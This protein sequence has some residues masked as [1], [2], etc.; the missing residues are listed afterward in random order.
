MAKRHDP[1][2]GNRLGPRVAQVVTKAMAQHTAATAGH[3]AKVGT[4]AALDFCKVISH[5]TRGTIGEHAAQVAQMEEAPLWFRKVMSFIAFGEGEWQAMLS[6]AYYGTGVQS[7][8]GALLGNEIAPLVQRTLRQD[9]NSLLPPG[10]AADLVARGLLTFEQGLHEASGQAIAEPRFEAMVAG[11]E[12]QPDMVTVL[13]LLRRGRIGEGAAREILRRGG[14]SQDRANLLLELRYTPPGVADAALQVIK[15]IISQDQ[16]RAVA[17]EN[18]VRESDFDDLVAMTGEPPGVQDLLFA[19]RRGIIGRERLEHGIRQGRLRNEWIDVIESLR[20]VPANTADA[21]RAVVQN[22]LS[23]EE[24]KRIAEENGLDPHHWRWLVETA[25]N[26][27]GPMEMLHLWK[28]GIMSEQEVRQGLRES[29]LKNKY[30]DAILA[31]AKTQ[32]AAR[33]ITSMIQHGVI[34]EKDGITLLLRQGYSPVD[35]ARLVQLG[36][37]QKKGAEERLAKNDVLK[38]YREHTIDE[39]TAVKQ[40][41][42]L[43]YSDHEAKVLLGFEDTRRAI[44]FRDQ[45]ISRVHTLYVN[46]HLDEAGASADL[47]VLGV[48]SAERD[49]LMALW[50]L[51][52]SGNARRMTEAQAAR[53]YRA[54]LIDETEFRR[55]LGQLGF[56]QPDVDVLV[57]LERGRGRGTSG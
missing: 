51:E 12:N 39:A 24:G 34:T 29:R 13:E 6:F 28:R 33:Q 20:F 18:G 57:Q 26:P 35:A 23:D 49:R 54:G 37:N 3:R 52:R 32:I 41:G 47:D 45:A 22:H 38:L 2:L 19:Y 40:L 14:Y 43:H 44:H 4:K 21:I 42:T 10:G 1:H 5:K 30:I 7:S 27:P 17:H 53:A 11:A 8:F 25:G 56:P 15:G 50:D 36:A 9:P 46:H 48:A 31:L 55:R 16:G